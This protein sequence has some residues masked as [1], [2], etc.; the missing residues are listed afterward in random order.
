MLILTF[1]R[2]DS[3]GTL[4]I[5]LFSRWIG[6]VRFT[7][8]NAFWGSAI[9][10]IGSGILMFG[11]GFLLQKHLGMAFIIGLLITLAFQT[12]FLRQATGRFSDFG[13]GA[14]VRRSGEIW[15]RSRKPPCRTNAY[16]RL[17]IYQ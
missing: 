6:R 8:A 4:L 15:R 1:C 7:F 10:H 2:R 9:G 13:A 17:S 16:G 11:L 5:F 12:V 3:G 14:S